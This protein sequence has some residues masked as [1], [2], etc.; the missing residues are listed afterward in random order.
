M[1]IIT[2]RQFRANQGRYIGMAHRGEDVYIKSRSGN[3]ILT[4]VADDIEE[5]EEAFQRYVNSPAFHAIAEKARKEMK[6]NR[7]IT[8]KTHEDIDRYFESL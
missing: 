5:D 3:V 4:P 6:E 8:L 1:T 7:C 2:G